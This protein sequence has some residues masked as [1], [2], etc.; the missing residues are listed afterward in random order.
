MTL[1]EGC[2]GVEDLV[3]LEPLEQE[4]LI[5]NLQLRYEKGEIYVSA[6]GCPCLWPCGQRVHVPPPKPHP[7]SFPSSSLAPD[8]HWERVGLSESLPTAAHL[9]PRVHC[10]IL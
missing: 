9:W 4:S 2:I 1:L 7:L 10:Q 6:Y 3:L 8:L 5:K